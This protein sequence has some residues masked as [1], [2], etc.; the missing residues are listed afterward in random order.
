MKAVKQR[1]GHGRHLDSLPM[2]PSLKSAQPL[3]THLPLIIRILME[4][5]PPQRSSEALFLQSPRALFH[6][7]CEVVIKKNKNTCYKLSQK[8][9]T[10][11][12]ND[13]CD[14]FSHSSLKAQ[15]RGINLLQKKQTK[16]HKCVGAESFI[17]IWKR[18]II[19]WNVQKIIELN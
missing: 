18:R 11:W 8:G 15:I 3:Q 4:K 2:C 5:L 9:F 6:S 13:K 1:H 10:L 14:S 19:A 17:F 16:E 7:E 12:F